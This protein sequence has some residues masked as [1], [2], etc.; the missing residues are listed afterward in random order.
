MNSFEW[1]IGI[2]NAE[3]KYLTAEG[4]GNKIN[5]AGSALRQ[6]QKWTVEFHDDETIYIRSYVGNYISVDRIGT[7]TCGT[8]E[9]GEDEQFF[10][11]YATDGSARWAFRSCKYKYFLSGTEEQINC[12]AKTASEEEL[13]LWYTPF[14]MHPQVTLFAMLGK[15][16]AIADDNY[17]RVV[18]I[19]AWGPKAL[20]TMEFSRGKYRF[21]TAGNRYLSKDGSL[22]ESPSDDTLFAIEIHLSNDKSL[23]GLA[24]QDN[25]GR[26]L[27]ATGPSGILKTTYKVLRKDEFFR[28]EECHPQVAIRGAKGKMASIG[29]EVMLKKLSHE[30]SRWEIFQVCIHF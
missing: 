7:V 8:K 21:K 18:G 9:R 25:D 4:Y 6:K 28:L 23:K 16:Y 5:V 11:E 30:P 2:F 15:K 20:L 19:K 14:A 27:S 17:I 1:V 12:L 10:L 13:S 29:M 26:Y 22:V 3:D 24:F